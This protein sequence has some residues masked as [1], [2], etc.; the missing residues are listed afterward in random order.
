[1]G[2]ETDLGK[3]IFGYRKSAVNQIIA[4]RDQ[5]LRQA[6]GRVRAAESKVADLET[7]LN[8]MRDRNARIDDQLERLRVQLDTVLQRTQE[9][10][11]GIAPTWIQPEAEAEAE[12]RGQSHPAADAASEPVTTPFVQPSAQTPVIEGPNAND[13]MPPVSGF[14]APDADQA[15]AQPASFDVAPAPVVVEGAGQTED[16]PVA[17]EAAGSWSEVESS[18]AFDRYEVEDVA[19]GSPVVEPAAE[20]SGYGFEPF[21]SEASTPSPEVESEAPSQ[22]DPDDA[23]WQGWAPSEE[24]P[25]YEAVSAEAPYEDLS[26]PE[27]PEDTSAFGMSLD[28]PT[29][30]SEPQVEDTVTETETMAV[31]EVHADSPEVFDEREPTIPPADL[32]VSDQVAEEEAEP[33]GPRVDDLTTRFLNDELAA[34]LHAAEESASRIVERARTTTQHEMA[35]SNRLW[36]EVQAEVARFASWR[37]EVEPVIHSVQSKVE[38]V[39]GYIDEVPERIRQALAPVAESISAIDADLAELAARA[40]PPLLLT[41]SG[42]RRNEGELSFESPAS[43]DAASMLG[44]DA[45]EVEWSVDQPDVELE[46]NEE[47]VTFDAGYDLGYSE[48]WQEDPSHPFDDASAG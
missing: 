47:P 30:G 14:E 15:E 26:S 39:R 32:D 11:S 3:G 5:M 28:E 40:T 6:E 42:V 24:T 25:A 33:D 38:S 17:W 45:P 34:I 12:P 29:W 4:D 8:S 27:V 20:G 23:I 43:D 9:A 13:A 7:E 36:R 21:S 44:G 18:S 31:D 37:D 41:P 2:S 46:S 1:M 10:A 22:M 16:E 48:G 19:S 35:E